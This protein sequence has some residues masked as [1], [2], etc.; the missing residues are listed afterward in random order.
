MPYKP[1]NTYDADRRIW[2]GQEE[3]HYFA[4]ELSI[5]EIIF[6][7]MRRH[8]KLIA[9]ISVT[10]NT[11]LTREEIHLNSMCVASY[12]RSLG[13]LQSDV[14]G[15]IAR[16]TTHIFAVTYGCFFNGIPFHALN[17]SYEQATIEKLFNITKPS[18]IFCDG[19]DYEKVKAA[20]AEL[21]VK[22]VT[23]RNHQ[24]GSISIDEVLATP[25]E[26]N[27]KPA[28]LEQGN[29]QTL[30]ILCSSGTTGTPKA[31][32]ITNSRKILNTSPDLTTADVQY[33]HSTLDWVTGLLTTVTSGVYSTKRIIADNPFDPA[34]LLQIIAEHKVTWL[35]QAPSHLAMIANCPEFE[36]ADLLSIRTYLY[37]GGRCSLEAQHKIRS[38][39]RNDCMHLAYG[40][41]EVGSA[42]SKNDH[43][44]KKPN[45]VGRVMDGFKLK[46]IDDQGKPLGPNEVGEVCVY[47]GQYWPGYYGN[48]KESHSVRDSAL[49]FHSGDLGYMDDDGFLYIVERKK[50]MLKY[51]N[52]M[53]YPHEIEDVI[54]QMPQVAEVCVFGIWN[55]YNGDEAAAAVI[56]KIGS[57]LHAQD[58]V[59]FVKQHTSAKYKQLH[60]G[61][62]IVDELKRTANGKT[63]RQAT[64][65]YF[66]E[67]KDRN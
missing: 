24:M 27:F 39:L 43:F 33:T 41:T 5:G 32:T 36:K 65:A 56:K 42:V 31:V 59:D 20:T 2:S 29:L 16:N 58:V 10:E 54:A 35:I 22:I 1:E 48:P 67:V 47:S 3:R 53:Y 61:A 38:R 66:L 37:G 30:A 15:I 21:E 51:Q 8:P 44:D 9:Q 55:E 63:N 64:K 25:V 12:L 52:I 28:H 4:P 18:I 57:T 19:E 62:I 45:S 7:E 26:E 60:G 11:V 34:H 13:L 49:W 17:I 40:F 50:E 6:H 46:I 14:V 23:M